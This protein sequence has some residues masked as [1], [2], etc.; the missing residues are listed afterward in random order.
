MLKAIHV[1]EGLQAAQEKA[2]KVV[3]LLTGMKNKA[4]AELI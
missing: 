1:Q 4:A 2:T 3:A